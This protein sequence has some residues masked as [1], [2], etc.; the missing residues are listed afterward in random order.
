MQLT[1]K[2]P[3]PHKNKTLI[4][5]LTDRYTYL[6]RAAWLERIAEGRL[7]Y[8][9]KPASAAT[10]L[11]QGGTVVYQVP[12]F[13]QPDA[14]FDYTIIYE[15]AWLVAVN[16]PTNLRVHGEGA[17]MM[18]NLSYHIR[19][20]HQPPYPDL[21][22][23]NR[24]DADT[25]GVVL[26]AKDRDTARAMM[27]LFERQA[28]QKTYLALVHGTPSPL[29]GTIDLAIGHLT[30]P[31][32]EKIG[33]IPRLGPAADKVKEAV[34]E[35]STLHT[36]HLPLA[37][38][39]D[40]LALVQAAGMAVGTDHAVSLVEL[41]PKTGRT[42][43]LRVHLA[44]L[45]CPIVGDRLYMLDDDRFVDWREN[46]SADRYGDLLDRHALHSL[47]TRFIHPH[48][49]KELT[50]SAPLAKDIQQLIDQLAG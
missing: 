25:S 50:V 17:Y 27:R 46:R 32:Y 15:D 19:H 40:R 44:H 49:Q 31:R 20:N 9:G 47:E 16:K 48:T 35:Y 30:N 5:Y 24:L 45:N 10:V 11:R 23:V 37:G 38:Y 13:P 42:H 14:N 39:A 26:L 3:S 6:D 8:N 7:T 33:R 4:D 41:R 2:V 36:Y 34:T 29:A 21:T 12:P 28:V 18:A 1:S 22:L 43:Q